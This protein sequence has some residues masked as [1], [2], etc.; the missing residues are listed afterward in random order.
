MADDLTGNRAMAI[1]TYN[2]CW[3]LLEAPRDADRD[4]DLLSAAFASRYHWCAVGGAQELIVADWM[5]SRAAAACGYAA[6][7]VEFADRAAAGVATGDHPAWLR[8]SVQEGRARAFAAAGNAEART[9]AIALAESEL[10]EEPDPEDRE[11]I[12]EQLAT[13]PECQQPED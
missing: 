12:A 10:A 13:V 5:A 4:A 6:L 1:S 7:A 3:Y 8:A 2:R 11:L 9:A